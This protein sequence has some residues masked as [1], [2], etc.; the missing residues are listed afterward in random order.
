[1]FHSAVTVLSDR[2]AIVG[3]AYFV[4][5]EKYLI[6]CYLTCTRKEKND[7]ED[8]PH[9]VM[10]SMR[11]SLAAVRFGR[12]IPMEEIVRIIVFSVY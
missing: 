9:L 5:Y 4:I 7:I 12:F 8:S 1:M 11:G 6:Q 3:T 10:Y 2:A